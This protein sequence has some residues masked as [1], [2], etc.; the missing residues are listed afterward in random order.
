MG[1]VLPAPVHILVAAYESLD[2][3]HYYRNLSST[4][5]R[6]EPEH[7]PRGDNGLGYRCQLPGRGDKTNIGRGDDEAGEGGSRWWKALLRHLQ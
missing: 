3:E 4:G 1:Q 5:A 2:E 7:M 6:Q